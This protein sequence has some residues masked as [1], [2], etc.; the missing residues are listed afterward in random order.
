MHPIGGHVDWEQLARAAG[1]TADGSGT[2]YSARR[3]NPDRWTSRMG[4]GCR[5]VAWFGGFAG[6]A[7][8]SAKRLL[9][10]RASLEPGQGGAQVAFVR[11]YCLSELL[12][13]ASQRAE[14]I[15]AAW[16]AA[17]ELSRSN[18]VGAVRNE[19]RGAVCGDRDGRTLRVVTGDL[20]A[21]RA[22]SVPEPS[23]LGCDVALA[24]RVD[25]RQCVGR[26]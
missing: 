15:P 19:R 18:A 10:S 2:V 11:R 6:L 7:L 12:P 13:R 16:A 8:P 24:Y 9:T 20:G 14:R 23:L 25:R 1:L 5:R 26:D 17:I 3:Q 22:V 21:V 4:H